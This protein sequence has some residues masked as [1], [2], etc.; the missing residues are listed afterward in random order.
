MQKEL[1]ARKD[2]RKRR[3]RPRKRLLEA[4]NDEKGWD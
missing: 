1:I 4:V 3:G 2:G